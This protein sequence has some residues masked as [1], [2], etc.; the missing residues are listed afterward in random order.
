MLEQTRKFPLLFLP[1][2]SPFPV[3]RHPAPLAG[4][5]KANIKK[6]PLSI[7]GQRDGTS[8]RSQWQFNSDQ[9]GISISRQR[10]QEI[11]SRT[12]SKIV[13]PDSRTHFARLPLPLLQLSLLDA[14]LATSPLIALCDSVSFGT[15][16][17][18]LASTTARLPSR[19]ALE[20]VLNTE[21]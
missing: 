2:L 12:L 20:K 16:S 15:L 5:A 17:Q 14:F 21:G 6:H 1:P 3:P 13:D 4:P 7:E 8:R 10:L 11:I 19:Q 18:Q 9:R